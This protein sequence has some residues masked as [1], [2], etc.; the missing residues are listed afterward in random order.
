MR[1][2][3]LPRRPS[4]NCKLQTLAVHPDPVLRARI[5]DSMRERWFAL[6]DEGWHDW[7][8]GLVK[9]GQYES[10]LEK[11]DEMRRA[12]IRIRPWLLELIVYELCMLGEVEEAAGILKDRIMAGDSGISQAVWFF[13]FDAACT[14]LHV[15]PKTR[16]LFLSNLS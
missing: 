14:L 13:L 1:L 15:S 12:N 16:F 4:T 8:V 7:I 3:I 11:M 10:A 6:S 2:R 9:E 5:I